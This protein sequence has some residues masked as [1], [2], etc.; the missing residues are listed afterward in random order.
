MLFFRLHH[1]AAENPKLKKKAASKSSLAMF[2]KQGSPTRS[3][4]G[5]CG[6]SYSAHWGHKEV[7]GKRFASFRKCDGCRHD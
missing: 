5:T 7:T 2:K 4:F 6:E 1:Q 3:T